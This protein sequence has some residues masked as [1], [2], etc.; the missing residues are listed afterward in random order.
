MESEWIRASRKKPCP[1]CN[2]F[3]WCL[4]AVNGS[5]AICP[6][7]EKGSVAYIDGS[8]WLHKFGDDTKAK[9]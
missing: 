3:D 5:A 7:A 6:R 2:K 8:G 1:V 4:I 9:T